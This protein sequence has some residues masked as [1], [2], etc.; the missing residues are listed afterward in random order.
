MKELTNEGKVKS[1]LPFL[2]D[3]HFET[4]IVGSFSVYWDGCP[5]IQ[6]IVFPPVAQSEL[7]L[8]KSFIGE[9]K[10]LSG[11]TVLSVKGVMHSRANVE[12]GL[13]VHDVG[14]TKVDALR[15]EKWS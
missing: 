13:H 1:G 11:A 10:V 3:G 4:A 9:L 12:L 7:S 6:V 14:E 15:L 8:Y 2:D 5:N